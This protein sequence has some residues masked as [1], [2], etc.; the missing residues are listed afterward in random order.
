MHAHRVEVLDRADH[1]DVVGPVAHQFELVLLP[2]E[3]RLLQKHLGGRRM[4]QS[5]TGDQPQLGLMPG[6]PRSQ[7]AHREGG[8]D[9]DRV[10]EILGRL[11]TVG[12]RVADPRPRDRR[13]QPV[14]R[15]DPIDDALE[16]LAVLTRLDRGHVGADQFDAV[17]VQDTVGVHRHRGVQCGLPPQ[18]G[19]QCVGAFLGDDRLD[20]LGR[21]RLDVGGVGELGIGHDRRRVRVD[22]DHPQALGAQH[23]ARLGAGV[24]ELAGLADHDRAG[25][26]H[27][28]AAQIL[29]TWHQFSSDIRTCPPSGRRSGRR[30]RRR[31]ADRPRPQGG[32]GR[33][34]PGRPGS[35]DPRRRRR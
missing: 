5:G 16:L 33:R 10:A 31:R 32:I 34:R 3:D 8:P 17:L 19:Q 29:A 4:V 30:D 28:H 27:H 14:G 24:V 1:H 20:H 22:Q 12:H 11:E 35:A 2:A 6:D 7:T 18:R 23:P 25:P 21:D 15:G 9:D 13:V 26:D